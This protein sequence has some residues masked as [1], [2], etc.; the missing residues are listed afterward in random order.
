MQPDEI[1]P[2]EPDE[3][4]ERERVEKL[5]PPLN[6]QRHLLELL[7]SLPVPSAA[8]RLGTP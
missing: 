7:V 5:E 6:N 2:G 8:A 3:F 4:V 1:V